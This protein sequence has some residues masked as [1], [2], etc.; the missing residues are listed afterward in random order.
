[1]IGPILSALAFTEV[2]YRVRAA[3]R[4]AVLGLVLGLTGAVA[5]GFLVAAAFVGLA[6]VLH[7]AWVC[8]IFAGL[9]LILALVVWAVKRAADRRPAAAGSAMLGAIGGSTATAA[10]MPPSGPARRPRRR[11]MPPVSRDAML[12]ALPAVAFI[13][14]LVVG[15]NRG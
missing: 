13:A 14:A 1:M 3:A 7:P 5:A 8:L 2:R 11:W 12:V 9:F 10:A 4:G 6:E 15:R